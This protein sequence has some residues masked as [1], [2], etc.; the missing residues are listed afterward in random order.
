MVVKFKL[1]LV[2]SGS[3][4]VEHSPRD[5]KVKGLSPATAAGTDREKMAKILSS[6][7]SGLAAVV[8]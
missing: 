4:V 7:F 8:Q 1:F 5:L 2:S 6:I 3:T